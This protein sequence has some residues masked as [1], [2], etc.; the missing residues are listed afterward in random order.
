MQILKELSKEKLVLMITHNEELAH[1]YADEFKR[2]NYK[3][4]KTY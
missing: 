2:W 3:Q 1:A 4:K